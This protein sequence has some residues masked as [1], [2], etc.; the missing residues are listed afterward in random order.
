MK[1]RIRPDLLNRIRAI[2]S[3]SRTTGQAT[4]IASAGFSAVG[5]Y[6]RSDRCSVG[7][8]TELHNV[9][10]R[11][12]TIY[13]K[14]YPT[15]DSYFSAS[16]GTVDGKADAAFARSM[17]QPAQTQI[18]ATVDYDPDAL[19]VSGP[20]INGRISDYMKGFQTAIG[21]YDYVASVYGSGRTCRILM[22][23]GLAKTGWL[24]QSEGFAEYE[25]FKPQARM[26][27]LSQVNSSWDADDIADSEVVGLW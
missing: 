24:S 21:S 15:S 22:D 16:K 3:S 26:L 13:E 4:Y 25:S 27:Q 17:G 19:N 20:T 11:V 18:Y 1:R 12:W 23:N 14:G 2:D 7:M 5:I 8:I 10:L 9:G 6:L